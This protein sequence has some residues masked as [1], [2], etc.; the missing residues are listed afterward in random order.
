MARFLFSVLP[1]RGHMYPTLPIAFALRAQGHA[2][3]MATLPEYRHLLEPHD[4]AYFPLDHAQGGARSIRSRRTEGSARDEAKAAFR[5]AFI[6]PIPDGVATIRQIC[7]AWR[8]DVLVNDYVTYA[9]LLV[10]E[11]E[12]IPVATITMTVFTW[13]GEVLGPFGLGL[14]PARDSATRAYYAL[15]RRQSESFFSDVLDAFN[16]I[17]QTYGLP[18]KA[19]SLA[20]ATLSPYLQLV[21]AIPA[22]DYERDDLPP[23][24]HYVGPCAFDPPSMFDQ[25]TAAWLAA[26]STD[27]PLVLAAASGAFTRS[28]GLVEAAL[29]G[30]ESTP[31]AVLATLPF[32]HPLHETRAERRADLRLVRFAA[33][34]QILPRAAVVVTH[35]GFGT[36]TKAL[37]QGLPLVVIPYAGDQPEVA[38]RVVWAGAGVRLNPAEL[39]GQTLRAA[40]ESV[41][42][43]QSYRDAAQSLAT[44]L[45]GYDGASRSAELL[46]WLAANGQPVCDRDSVGHA[47]VVGVG[48]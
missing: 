2:V 23:H 31:L 5:T 43:D 11:I 32:D 8:P 42:A 35:G 12:G 16:A 15:L 26:L 45:A 21:Q 46:V 30:L 41:L 37:C 10:G 36:V 20:S 47:P 48:G 29:T 39:T 38:Q 40:V 22:L 24:V 18:P 13:P 44:R 6:A 19:G 7:S 33:H 34:S 28:A 9:P 3:A 1:T 4:I 27:Q 17:R 25:E 14:P